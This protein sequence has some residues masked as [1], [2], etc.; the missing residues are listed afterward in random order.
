MPKLSAS[1]AES[2]NYAVKADIL[3]ASVISLSLLRGKKYAAYYAV[4]TGFLF[5]LTVGNPY[6]FSPLVY[7]ACAYLAPTAASP[8]SHRS[9]LSAALVGAMLLPIKSIITVFYLIA[10]WRDATVG[11]II[12]RAVI[13]E[14][15][16]NVLAVCVM[17]SAV[18]ILMALFKI[19]VKGGIR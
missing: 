16:V 9:P 14:Y 13:P 3:L 15:I 10:V 19:P 18:R 6:S 12:L 11:G 4:I 17:F 1:I 5:D 2:L 8:F 7:Y